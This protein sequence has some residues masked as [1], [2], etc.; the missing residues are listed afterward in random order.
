MNHPDNSN[1]DEEGWQF[2]SL[3]PKDT[4]RQ[5]NGGNDNNSPKS[6]I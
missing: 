3:E 4:D 6:K 5:N 1:F 2:P